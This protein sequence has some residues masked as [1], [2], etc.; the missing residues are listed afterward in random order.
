MYSQKRRDSGPTGE[1]DGERAGRPRRVRKGRCDRRRSRRRRDAERRHGQQHVFVPPGGRRLGRGRSPRA[2]WRRGVPRRVRLWSCSGGQWR[3]G[4]HVLEQGRLRVRPKRRRL[5]AGGPADWTTVLGLRSVGLDQ[6]G[7]AGGRS[8]GRLRAGQ[9][10][11]LSPQRRNLGGRGRA[12]RERRSRL[13]PL[14]L[15]G[16]DPGRLRRHRRLDAVDSGSDA[17]AAYVFGRP[18]AR[19]SSGRSSSR[20]RAQAAMRAGALRSAAPGSGA[21]SWPWGIRLPT[22]AAAP[23]TSTRGR[24]ERGGFR[25]SS[26]PRMPRCGTASVR[27]SRSTTARCS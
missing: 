27:R 2:E 5:D 23:S 3:L 24:A 11:R 8:V 21:C 13:G 22:R 15:V 20:P 18:V 12:R 6:R 4:G 26:P 19:G 10:V 14:R 17:G 1:A 7:R 16:V 25:R 9:R